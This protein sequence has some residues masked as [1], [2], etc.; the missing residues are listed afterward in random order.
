MDAFKTILAVIGLVLIGFF[1]GFFTHRQ[2][3]VKRIEKIAD[4]ARGPGFQRQLL[5]NLNV[6]AEQRKKL[7]P[8]VRDFGRRMA[9]LHRDSR[10]KRRAVIDSLHNTIKPHLTPEQTEKLEKFSRRFRGGQRPGG[11]PPF[12]GEKRQRREKTG[13]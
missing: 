9:E 11:R 2:M 4:M 13:E 3:T 6:T 1:A 10:E 7:D 8:V 5:D 12:K